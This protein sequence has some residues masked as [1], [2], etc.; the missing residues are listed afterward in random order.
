MLELLVEIGD[1][2][3][4][5]DVSKSFIFA[6]DATSISSK[7]IASNTAIITTVTD[8]NLEVGDKVVISGVDATFDG[9]YTVNGVTTARIFTYAKTATNAGPTA[10]DPV[11]SLISANNWLELLSPTVGTTG[12]TGATGAGGTLGYYGSFYDLTDQSLVYT[13]A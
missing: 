2:A 6:S 10:V 8:H 13:T 3:I 12:P 5:S 7:E 9:T 11:G 4:R 1:V